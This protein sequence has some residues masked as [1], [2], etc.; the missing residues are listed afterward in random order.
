[1]FVCIY[2]CMYYSVSG[3]TGYWGVINFQLS[4]KNCEEK[5]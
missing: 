1:M 3:Q 5:G 2:L 4:S